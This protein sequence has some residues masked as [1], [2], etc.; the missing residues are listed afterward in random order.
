MNVQEQPF[1]QIVQ[2]MKDATAGRKQRQTERDKA[3]KC[4]TVCD[5]MRDV[6]IDHMTLEERKKLRLYSPDLELDYD[7]AEVEDEVEEADDAEFEAAD[8]EKKKLPPLYWKIYRMLLRDIEDF[9]RGTM[10]M[11][12]LT[13][14]CSLLKKGIEHNV[15][16]LFHDPMKRN[17]AIARIDEELK[18][19]KT[20]A[21]HLKKNKAKPAKPF[22]PPQPEGGIASVN[23]VILMKELNVLFDLLDQAGTAVPYAVEN[24][25]YDEEFEQLVVVRRKEYFVLK[26]EERAVA[27]AVLETP[28]T[29]NVHLIRFGS[30]YWQ[31]AETSHDFQEDAFFIK[32]CIDMTEA[33]NEVLEA[34]NTESDLEL[35]DPEEGGASPFETRSSLNEKLSRLLA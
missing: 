7:E 25:I 22:N 10:P 21:E 14:A 28:L 30:D 15:R 35:V 27:Y 17:A 20:Q 16:G 12:D 4:K 33:L 23:A 29:R 5:L 6:M 13:E 11:K 24:H 34:L 2:I 26:G 18:Q 31:D 8:E 9:A 1:K 3:D 32:P 19:I